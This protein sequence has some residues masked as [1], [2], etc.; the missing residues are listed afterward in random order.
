MDDSRCFQ[1]F[2][3]Q[4]WAELFSRCLTSTT[5]LTLLTKRLDSVCVVKTP[6]Q[7]SILRD[8]LSLVSVVTG[9]FLITSC[10]PPVDALLIDW[11]K[12]YTVHIFIAGYQFAESH[13]WQF[14]LYSFSVKVRVIMLLIRKLFCI[15]EDYMWSLFWMKRSAT[16]DLSLRNTLQCPLWSWFWRL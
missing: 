8:V 4:L 7:S 1:T 2:R 16:Q 5:D 15:I 3:S 6:P 12:G 9:S 13:L 10:F 11:D 14:Y